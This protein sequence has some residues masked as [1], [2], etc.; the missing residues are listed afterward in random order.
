MSKTEFIEQHNYYSYPKLDSGRNPRISGFSE[1]ISAEY[2]TTSH[3]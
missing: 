2:L 3:Y 1:K